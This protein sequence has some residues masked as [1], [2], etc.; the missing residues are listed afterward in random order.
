MQSITETIVLSHLSFSLEHVCHAIGVENR[1]LPWWCNTASVRL[2]VLV[3]ECYFCAMQKPLFSFCLCSGAC[4]LWAL[5]FPFPLCYCPLLY[6]AIEL[7][8]LSL[9]LEYYCCAIS[10]SGSLVHDITIG[11]EGKLIVMAMAR[12]GTTAR[13][14]VISKEG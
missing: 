12:H 14:Q 11:D 2:L 6:W 10:C 3:H 8:Q 5:L 9:R 7:Y 1:H 4:S 13:S